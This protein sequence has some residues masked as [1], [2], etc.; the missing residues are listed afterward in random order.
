MRS[1]LLIRAGQI[2]NLN[3]FR[4]LTIIIL[5]SI[6]IP[7]LTNISIHPSFADSEP[8][9]IWTDKDH[10]NEGDTVTIYGK[11]ITTNYIGYPS[12]V[13][14]ELTSSNSITFP[15]STVKSLDYDLGTTQ[16]SNDGTFSK[17][18]I[19]SGNAYF[20]TATYQIFA[21][22]PTPNPNF[23]N[24]MGYLPAGLSTF[25][26]GDI[27]NKLNPFQIVLN[28]TTSSQRI[29]AITIPNNENRNYTNQLGDAGSYGNFKQV[30]TRVIDPEGQVTY[31]NSPSPIP[32]FIPLQCCVMMF[33]TWQIQTTWGDNISVVKIDV[34]RSPPQIGITF[35][36]QCEHPTFSS[37]TAS[38]RELGAVNGCPT[39]FPSYVQDDKTI[40][41]IVF[42][43]D[44]TP[45]QLGFTYSILDPNGNMVLS[46][47]DTLTDKRPLNVGYGYNLDP[48]DN[49]SGVETDSTLIIPTNSFHLDGNYTIKID[50]QGITKISQFQFKGTPIESPPQQLSPSTTNVQFDFTT[51]NGTSLSGVILTLNDYQQFIVIKD[52]RTILSNVRQTTSTVNNDLASL[53]RYQDNLPP[54]KQ[55][56]NIQTCFDNSTIPSNQQCPTSQP[57][58]TSVFTSTLRDIQ[59]INQAKASQIIAAEINVGSNQAQTTSI[60]NSVS[61]QT[62]NNTPD[63]LNINIS[64]SNQT[65]PKVIMFNLNATT[66][67]V[68]NLKDLGVMYDGKPIHPAPNMDT[69]LHAKPTDSPSFAIVVTQ[70]GVQILVLV[71]HFS[72]H[73]ITITNMSKVISP[74]IPEFGQI[75]TMI[76]TIAIVSIIAVST[77]IGL[78]FMPKV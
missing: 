60:D 55:S 31:I 56:K 22:Y 8:S 27:V 42:V 37:E 12:L 52:P 50:Y 71:P 21:R 65:S 45:E 13:D 41:F 51:L 7:T 57:S 36:G 61:V 11:I 38:Q 18:F 47:S 33:G 40:K 14:F 20:G 35:Y 9:N 53:I 58:T 16:I 68:A 1:S 77:N 49:L 25:T 73:S 54:I 4:I 28:Q 29:F 34:P 23:P 67:N 78:R 76:L 32:N 5:V 72:T 62:T 59:N 75:T 30:I 26:V 48:S 24:I 63:S 19:L 17:S 69:I 44:K 70:S 6:A 15:N 46:K 3:Y 43:V 66:I 2:K 64:A 39:P 74:S 10:Y